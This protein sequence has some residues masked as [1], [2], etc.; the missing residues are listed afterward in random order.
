MVKS[1]L[2]MEKVQVV[3]HPALALDKKTESGPIRPV[4]ITRGWSGRFNGQ[5][6]S[7]GLENLVFSGLVWTASGG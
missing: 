7:N 5:H 1:I 4:R 3:L 2:I 6:G